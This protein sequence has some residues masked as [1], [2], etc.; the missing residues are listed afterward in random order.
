MTGHTSKAKEQGAMV[1]CQR[2][3]VVREEHVA[4][5]GTFI[6][7]DRSVFSAATLCS[8]LLADEAQEVL[9]V[10]IFDVRLR[11]IAYQEVARGLLS[12]VPALP[13]NIVTPALL[14]N[15]H[16]IIL[17]HNHPSGDPTPS[18][19]DLAVTDRVGAACDLLGMSL[20]DHLVVGSEGRVYSIRAQ[21]VIDLD[22]EE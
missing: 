1:T 22:D 18:G 14:V 19:A 5:L 20:L 4:P 15:G 11:L 3:T 13:R 12:E 6:D 2:L 17:C 9:L 16:S 7:E 21:E 10:L 8:G